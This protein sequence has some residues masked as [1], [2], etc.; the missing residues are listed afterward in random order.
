M[1]LGDTVMYLAYFANLTWTQNWFPNFL[2]NYN[3]MKVA[4]GRIEAFLKS[5]EI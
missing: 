4:F 1:E 3:E 5:N 2:T